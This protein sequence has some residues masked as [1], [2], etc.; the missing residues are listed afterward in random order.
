MLLQEGNRWKLLIEFTRFSVN[1]DKTLKLSKFLKSTSSTLGIVEDI[2]EIFVWEKVVFEGLKG[3]IIRHDDD[4]L[5]IDLDEVK[6]T[7]Q[8]GHWLFLLMTLIL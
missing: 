4:I 8:I 2:S 7:L 1:F 6:C 3:S 5:E